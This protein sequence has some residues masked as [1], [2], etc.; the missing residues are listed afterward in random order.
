MCCAAFGEPL[1]MHWTTRTAPEGLVGV[2]LQQA[3]ACGQT[4]C[5]GARAPCSVAWSV[6][7]LL[8]TAESVCSPCLSSVES[9]F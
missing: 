7:S 8:S 1:T 2:L 4:A 5:A 9:S 3:V 6:C